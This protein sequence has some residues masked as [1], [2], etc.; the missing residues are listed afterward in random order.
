MAEASIF[1]RQWQEFF[2][3]AGLMLVVM[4]IFAFMA[5]CYRYRNAAGEGSQLQASREEA[6]VLGPTPALA[7]ASGSTD[8]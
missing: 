4:V 2:F 3:F 7:L 8:V 1:E 5:R 6:P